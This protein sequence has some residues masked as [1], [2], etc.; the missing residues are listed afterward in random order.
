MIPFPDAVGVA[1]AALRLQRSFTQLYATRTPPQPGRVILVLPPSHPDAMRQRS[2]TT[3]ANRFGLGARPGDL[4]RIG[5]DATGWLSAQIDPRR[6]VPAR[7]AGYPGSEEIVREAFAFQL[8]G[9]PEENRDKVR[10]YRRRFEAE[11][12][13]RLLTMSASDTPFAERMVL[14]WSNHF[15]VARS[16]GITAAA[17]G[18]YEREAIRPHV[19]GR[20]EDMLLAVCR[21]PCMTTY[22]DNMVS[23]GP[24]SREGGGARAAANPKARRRGLNENLGREILELHT[25]GVDGGYRQEDV[26]ELAMAIS[27][28]THGGRRSRRDLEAGR[29]IHGNFEFKPSMHEP[30]TRTVLSRRYADDGEAQGETILRDLARHPSTAKHVAT[31]LVRHFVDDDPPAQDIARIAAVFERSGGDLAEISRALIGLDGAWRRPLS[32]V[33][34]PYE[35]VCSTLRAV[36]IGTSDAGDSIRKPERFVNALR[37]MG[38]LPFGATSPAGWPDGARHWV[39]PDALMRRIEWVRAAARGFDRS[40]DPTSVLDSAL[41][42]Q[43]SASTR[44]W[45]ERAPSPDAALAMVFASHEFQ[46]R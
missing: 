40:L 10:A 12:A 28:W 17:L 16:R 15:T 22:L 5:R 41:A 3:A 20:F 4:E 23:V 13:E 36:G 21:H 18:A 26:V 8:A 31:R 45:V 39:S 2:A 43:A 27:G 14:F 25:L 33:K 9:R 7:L 19:F 1:I 11:N 34:T 30:G 46:R 24:N 35:F 37:Q 32:K 38:H 42:E 29:A 6:P 44:S